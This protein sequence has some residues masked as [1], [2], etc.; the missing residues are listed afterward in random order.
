MLFGNRDQFALEIEPVT[1]AWQ[2]KYLPETTAWAGLSVWLSGKNTCRHL[3]HG[4]DRVQDCVYVP[5]A[6]IADW[7]ASS[8]N[9][10]S[11][12]ETTRYAIKRTS[13]R[14]VSPIS[15]QALMRDWEL[16]RPPH[17]QTQC[18]WE[19]L[20]YEWWE[21]HFL[22]AGAEGSHLPNLSF[23]RQED[24]LWI[25]VGPIAH[26]GDQPPRFIDDSVITVIP[27]RS[28]SQTIRA[29]VQYVGIHLAAAG[30]NS[31]FPWCT[32]EDPLA[33][34]SGDLLES[35]CLFTGRNT[36]E[37]MLASGVNDQCQI[38]SALGIL[39]DK[40]PSTSA[41]TQVIRDLS[42][43]SP[44]S[45]SAQMNHLLRTLHE[46]TAGSPAQELVAI[47]RDFPETTQVMV[48]PEE[49]GYEAARRVRALHSLN[50]DPIEDVA[51]LC[52]P[53]GIRTGD[54]Q[55]HQTNDRMIVG[56]GADSSAW[57]AVLKSPRTESLNACRFE[58]ARGL[59]HL[60]L[61]SDRCGTIGAASSPHA[62]EFRRRRSGAFAAE[63][64]LP[65]AMLAQETSLWSNSVPDLN[66]FRGILSRYGV[67][68][69][70]AAYQLWNHDLLPSR[71]LLEELLEI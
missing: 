56:A 17:G 13:S 15:L 52:R 41:A 18:S 62:Q 4:T 39:N 45:A 37:L 70:T 2:T 29:F 7:F 10:I 57:I 55:W 26:P 60:L 28:A 51:E 35:I 8:W 63:L 30:L 14:E 54:F 16:S 46:Q 27:W 32:K 49:H 23:F 3:V 31:L 25:E 61:D 34:T 47:R 19:D 11:F 58:I 71:D 24:L 42:T 36:D 6:P 44:C 69:T 40:D 22:L 5:L 67:G 64:L 12:E 50:K 53:F 38:A 65:A 21:R 48:S 1:P 59:G 66:A 68:K 43:A 9:A 33:S 20:R